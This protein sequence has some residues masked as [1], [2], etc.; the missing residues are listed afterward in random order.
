MRRQV[1]EPFSLYDDLGVPRAASREEVDAAYERAIALAPEPWVRE[2]LERAWRTLRD[3]EARAQYDRALGSAG[4]LSSPASSDANLIEWLFPCG[5]RLRVPPH[6]HGIVTC[7]IDK[8]RFDWAP[9][10]AELAMRCAE[11]GERYTVVFSRKRK[12]EAFTIE[13]YRSDHVPSGRSAN[14]PSAT[15]LALGGDDLSF[16]SFICPSCNYASARHT[17]M[18][19]CGSCESYVC[20]ASVTLDHAGRELFACPCGHRGVISGVIASYDARRGTNADDSGTRRLRS[21]QRTPL[22]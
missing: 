10:T 1:A 20:G 6:S 7:P 17:T 13:S 16:Y 19:R 9:Q 21:A 14:S 3:P 15:S 5:H 2:A 11:T 8:R 18:V 22:R 4:Q 12:A